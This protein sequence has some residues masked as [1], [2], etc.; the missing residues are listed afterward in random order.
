[1]V[2]GLLM[3]TA[4]DLPWREEWFDGWDFYDASQSFEFRKA[5]Y[6]VV[7]PVQKSYWY[8]H[9]DKRCL[10]LWDY[11]RNRKIFVEKYLQ[12]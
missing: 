10:N 2:D 3:V 4:Y 9:D 12:R 7:V 11:N 1:M 6:K 8:V 5:G